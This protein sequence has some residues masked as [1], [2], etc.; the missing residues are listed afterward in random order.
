MVTRVD[1]GLSYTD[2]LMYSKLSQ[3]CLTK[4]SHVKVGLVIMTE[5]GYSVLTI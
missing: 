4:V 5:V 3:Q 1:I 2:N